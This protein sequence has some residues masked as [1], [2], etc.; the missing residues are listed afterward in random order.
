MRHTEFWN[1][2]ERALGKASYMHWAQNQAIS[3]LDSRT[4][5]EALADGVPPRQ[6]WR[7]VWAVLE[8]PEADR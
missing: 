6:V 7:A 2:M 5:V 1:R 8:L 4:P 3:E